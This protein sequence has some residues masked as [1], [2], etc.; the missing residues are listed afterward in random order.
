MK[1]YVQ[2]DLEADRHVA[3]VLAELITGGSL[4]S[5]PGTGALAKGSDEVA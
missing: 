3:T 2:S 5:V 4:V 1:Q